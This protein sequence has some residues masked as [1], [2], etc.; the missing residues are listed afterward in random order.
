MGREPRIAEGMR[1]DTESRAEAE[2]RAKRLLLSCLTPE[3]R[4]M[5]EKHA[6]FRVVSNLGNVF[7]LRSERIHNVRR[8]DAECRPIEEWCVT[9]NGRIPVHDVL[10]AQ[11]VMLETDELGLRA[12]ANVW[13]LPSRQMVQWGEDQWKGLHSQ[14]D[15]LRMGA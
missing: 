8:L 2:E 15:Y 11:K 9:P 3:Q 13:S 1:I 4:A 7:E 5:F 12:R 10:L 14:P 6:G